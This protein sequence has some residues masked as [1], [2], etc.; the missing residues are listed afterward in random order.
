MAIDNSAVYFP[1]TALPEGVTPGAIRIV[2]DMPDDKVTQLR[3]DLSDI[4]G[5]FVLET[6]LLS[7][8]FNRILDTFTMLPILLSLVALFTG[9]IVVANAIALSTMER[10][11][12]I[13]IMKAVGLQRRRVL[14]MLLMENSIMGL[15]AGLIG[16]GVSVLIL[17]LLLIAVFEREL[18]TD[19]PIV[20]AFTLMMACVGISLVAALLSVWGASSEK[21]LKVL[22]YE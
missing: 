10:R 18:G 8:L 3:R 19:I 5:T 15:L 11:R 1:R 9:G 20:T 21:P 6:R 2:V 14:G 16:V 7:D 17:L 4:P 13:A 12:E 22:R